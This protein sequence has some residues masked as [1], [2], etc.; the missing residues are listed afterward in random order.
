[1]KTDLREE[2]ISRLKGP[3]RDYN[4]NYKTFLDIGKEIE[5]TLQADTEI[6]SE[7][8]RKFDNLSA[9]VQLEFEGT[10]VFDQEI[11]NAKDLLYQSIAKVNESAAVS[12]VVNEDLS[13]ISDVL[14]EIHS[15]GMQLDDLIKNI[16][17]VSE[18]IEVASRNAGI[19]AFHAGTQGR[20]FEVI[21]R[22]M[23]GL[24]RS[25]Q[26]PT[27]LI[28][29]ISAGIINS[30]VELGS[31]LQKIMDIVANLRDI[32]DKYS[33]I[34]NDLLSFIPEIEGGI[35]GVSDSITSQKELHS[36]L[37][38][39]NDKLARRLD[40]VYDTARASAITEIH[41]SAM[42]Q[43][44]TNIKDDLLKSSDDSS[45][46]S[47]YDSF[48][49][50]LSGAVKKEDKM[51]RGISLETF[52]KIETQSSDRVILQFVSEASHLNQIIQ[53]IANQVKNW[54]K[55]NNL[56][57]DV[58]SKGVLFYEDITLI[59]G[60]LNKRISGIKQLTDE[61]N[62]PLRD[63]KKITERS[64]I[65][66]LYAGIES[67]RGGEFASSLGVVTREIKSLSQK[68][69]SF[70]DRIDEIGT[71]MLNDFV[72]LSTNIGKSMS[73]VEHG[74]SLLRHAIGAASENKRVLDN[75][76]NLSSEMVESIANM[77]SQCKTLEVKIKSFSEDYKKIGVDF[78]QYVGAIRSSTDASERILDVLN[79]HEKSVSILERKAKT[80][81][82]CET[83][84]PLE[85]D[86]AYKTDSTSHQVVTQIFTGLLSFDSSLHLIPGV[87]DSFTVSKDG[88]TWDFTLKRGV[89]FHDGSTVTARD[90][91]STIQRVLRGP[92]MSFV[93][94]A[95]ELV[96]LDD[97]RVRFTLKYPYLPFLANLACGACDIT[98]LDFSADKPVGCG[99]YK[100]MSWE[101]GRE[102]V[103]EAN[104]GFFD[105]QPPIQQVIIKIIPDSNESLALFREGKI[106]LMQLSSSITSRFK[107]AEVKTGPVLSTQYIGINMRMETPFKDRRVRQAL[108]H[109]LDREHFAKTIMQNTAVPGYGIFPPGMAVFNNEL[110]SYRYDLKKARDLM[111]EAGYPNGIDNTFV[112]DIREGQE[113]ALRA[114]YIRNSLDKIGVK[115]VLNPLP[116]RDLLEK[117][118]KGESVLAMRGWVSDNGDPDNFLFP[119]F[120]SRS[121][122]RPGNISYYQ[123][124][125]IEDMIE[126]A[127]SERSV[128]RRLQLYQ[129]MERIIVHDAPWIFLSHGVDSWAVR[130]DVGGFK[131]DPFGIVR[132]RN[133]WCA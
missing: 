107:A 126:T 110:E 20:G 132:F 108:N 5:F 105:G 16:N 26:V 125:D 106:S 35:K 120:H 81:V 36:I 77:V 43:H 94:Y 69:T 54:S 67:A 119:L 25:S 71:Q 12:N 83:E 80:L 89:K 118:Y 52:E 64:R 38:K 4:E 18:S 74:I 123:N 47:I 87:A 2:I 78:N 84:D 93:D 100:F 116:W 102:I 68:T 91:V 31:D 58:L 98:P 127:R 19:T 27:R 97:M 121:F 14:Q 95:D 33:H 56:T 133:L 86:P 51:F 41:L 39:E 61:I 113:A 79:D 23:T 3:L 111:K 82:F 90:V 72:Q 32:T 9:T 7:I 96:A 92:N 45:F 59:L 13:N 62:S 109:A 124:K 17:I 46:R 60:T 117:S 29:N 22:E 76:N 75:L 53:N 28:P 44:I 103:L 63:L 73:D 50:V 42:F 55:T 112:L 11:K 129:K 104:A 122:G 70:V 114:E 34:V 115:L 30:M 88:H 99:P 15:E 49:L 57:I 85:L 8:R 1:M 21:A 24:V 65:L 48:G 128:K 66:G 131:V 6:L 101:R 10:S 130:N 37:H 40:E